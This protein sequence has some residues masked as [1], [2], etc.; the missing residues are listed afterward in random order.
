[1]MY[2]G[3][4]WQDVG[5]GL[6][7]GTDWLNCM[8]VYNGEL[9]VGGVFANGTGLNAGNAIMRWNGTQ[10]NSVGQGLQDV[11]GSFNPG[12]SV[13]CMTAHA[14]RLYVG[15]YQFHAGYVPSEYISSWDGSQ[16]CNV[17]DGDFD[18]LPL[19]SIAFYHDT[20]F[21]A[22]G[23]TIDGDT[24]NRVAKWVGGAFA[25][26]CSAPVS[27]PERSADSFFLHPN[28][29]STVLTITSA[30]SNAATVLLTDPL[31]RVV[32]QEPLHGTTSLNVQALARGPYLAVLLDARGNRLGAM[33][34]VKE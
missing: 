25:D 17:G 2:D 20:L 18:L 10:W 28:P 15:G 21:I 22:T 33:R 8:E 31:G 24:V 34:W 11:S 4:T 30:P 16:W 29:A 7:G 12:M 32:L 3:S 19:Q 26:T 6:L 23:N 14:G 9:Y 1:M 13:F 5:G 27:M